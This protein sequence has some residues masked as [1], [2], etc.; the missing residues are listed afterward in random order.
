MPEKRLTKQIFTWDYR[1]VLQ[2]KKGWNAG[3]KEIL[4]N[5][6]LEDTFYG[7][8]VENPRQVM[9]SLESELVESEQKQLMNQISEMAKLRTYKEIKI[10]PGTEK[11]IQSNMNKYHRSLISK[12]R[13]GVFP[14]NIE[15][16]RHKTLR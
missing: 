6:K 3:I 8:D 7:L 2:G 16:G 9:S 13:I 4:V 10:I 1:R 5:N 12:F 11:Y 14:I 15:L